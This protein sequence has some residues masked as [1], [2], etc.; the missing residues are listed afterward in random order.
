M[1]EQRALVVTTSAGA[2]TSSNGA[3]LRVADVVNVLGGVGCSVTVVPLTDL[4]ALDGEWDLGVAVSY[5]CAGAVARLRDRCPR[6]WLDAVDSW[7]SVDISGLR[8]GHPSYALRMAR[9]AWRLAHA[10]AADV[11]TYISEDDL[12]RDRGTVRGARR[13]V[14]PGQAHEPPVAS[15]STGRR[16]VLTGDWGYLPNRDALRWFRRRVLPLLPM[17]VQVFGP[18]LEASDRSGLIVNGYAADASVLYRV[19]DIHLAPVLGGGGVNRKVLQPLLAGLPVVTTPFG[20]RG[21]RP[22]PLLVVARTPE[23]FAAAVRHWLRQDCEVLD[24]APQELWA[25]DDRPELS[26]WISRAP[27]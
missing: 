10:P 4:G 5:A 6:V 11:V 20:A 2:G 24:V 21:L 26:D 23:H 27:E 19:G 9:D 17:P 1:V 13:L 16:L 18:G 3:T 14:L 8:R 12:R 7:L 22:H 25:R 15:A